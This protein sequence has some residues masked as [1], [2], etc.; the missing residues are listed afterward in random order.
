MAQRETQ[1]MAPS[2]TKEKKNQFLQQNYMAKTTQKKKF[3]N[4]YFKEQVAKR[5]AAKR[6]SPMKETVKT[7]NL[8]TSNLLD[9]HAFE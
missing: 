3:G 1:D 8:K 9:S 2:Q 4:I 7:S 5:P 6:M